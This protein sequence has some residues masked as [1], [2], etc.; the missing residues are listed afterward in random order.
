MD[1]AGKGHSDNSDPQICHRKHPPLSPAPR[2]SS[3]AYSNTGTEWPGRRLCHVRMRACAQ[4]VATG[5][6]RAAS[7]A[8]PA[9]R[10]GAGARG[11]PTLARAAIKRTVAAATSD[12]IVVEA[13]LACWAHR[14]DG[15]IHTPETDQASGWRPPALVKRNDDGGWDFDASGVLPAF[16]PER[17]N[18]ATAQVDAKESDTDDDDDTPVIAT[19]NGVYAYNSD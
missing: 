15:T 6:H 1:T 11:A 4:V 5:R 17:R 2:P 14:T 13:V 7:M 10:T 19:A 8:L 16:D 12:V 3:I 9:V 18:G